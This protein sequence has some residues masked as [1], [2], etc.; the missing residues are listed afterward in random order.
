M[1]HQTTPCYY[2]HDHCH[3]HPKRTGSKAA[4]SEK[5][6]FWGSIC[7]ETKIQKKDGYHIYCSFSKNNEQQVAMVILKVV[8]S[9]QISVLAGVGKGSSY[10]IHTI[11]KMIEQIVCYILK[12]GHTGM[13]IADPQH[14]YV[15]GQL[16]PYRPGG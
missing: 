14:H 7:L 1:T 9:T 15:C 16:L 2:L 13:H 8:K 5:L 11:I 6:L 3:E 4:D 10:E 12:V